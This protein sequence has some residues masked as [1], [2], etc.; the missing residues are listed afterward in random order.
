VIHVTIAAKI[1]FHERIA[2]VEA[3]LARV[4]RPIT[5]RKATRST[6]AAS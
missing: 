5:Q 4:P 3:D 6:L 1:R 2:L